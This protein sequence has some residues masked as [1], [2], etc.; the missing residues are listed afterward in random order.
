MFE[1]AKTAQHV[2]NMCIRAFDYLPPVDVTFGDYLRAL[3]T[4]DPEFVSGDE[5]RQRHSMGTIVALDA[6]IAWGGPIDTFVTLGGPLGWEYV[7]DGLG[8]LQYPH[9]I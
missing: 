9:D 1:A 6:T 2:L 5:M 3:V 7:N 8:R 4:A